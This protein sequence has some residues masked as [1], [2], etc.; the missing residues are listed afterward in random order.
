MEK[1]KL[2]R[3]A[4][5][6]RYTTLQ[7]SHNANESHTAGAMSMT[8]MGAAYSFLLPSFSVIIILFFLLFV[9]VSFYIP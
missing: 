4:Q 9:T 3:L 2:F 5:N 7:L 6:V 8:D 1:N